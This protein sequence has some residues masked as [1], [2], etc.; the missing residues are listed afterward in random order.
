MPAS[1]GEP[2]RDKKKMISSEDRLAF[3]GQ[4]DFE[5]VCEVGRDAWE[6]GNF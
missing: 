3:S 1:A 5:D 2:G 4:S 6:P